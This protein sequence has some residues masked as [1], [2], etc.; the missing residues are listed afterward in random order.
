[1]KFA[2]IGAGVAGS[3]LGHM[4]NKQNHDVQ[5]FE[6]S[7]QENHWPVCA[8]GTSLKGI[9]IFA[10]KTGFDFNKYI[11]HRGKTAKV[12]NIDGKSEEVNVSGL[13]TYDKYKWESDLLNGLNVNYGVRCNKLNF[14]FHDYDY[15]IDCT[16]MN[17]EFLP[18][19]PF[20]FIIPSYEYLVENVENIDD[21][22]IINYRD[23]K[24]YF[25]YFPLGNKCGFVG[26]GDL[27]RNFHGISEFFKQNPNV[28]IIKKI[29]RP[30]RLTPPAL[31]QPFSS[32]NVIGAGEA[33]GCVFPFTG[34]GIVPS[35]ISCDILI[36][37][38]NNNFFDPMAY[39]EMILKTFSHFFDAYR[40]INLIANNRVPFIRENMNGL[41][42]IIINNPVEGHKI[43]RIAN[44]I[45]FLYQINYSSN[46]LDYPINNY[47]KL[48]QSIRNSLIHLSYNLDNTI[49]SIPIA[50]FPLFDSDD[51]LQ[52]SIKIFQDIC[53]N[54]IA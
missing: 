31:M 7:K 52:K 37:C 6:L 27:D 21:F 2:I 32:R 39:R 25:W 33:I 45:E 44:L 1:M 22:I 9:S 34:E 49:K 16:G 20:D 4:L 38:I 17:R 18:K 11:L 43:N 51:V 30:I 47:E 42:R 12:L 29:G 35:L 36:N 40:I 5:I 41:Q 54:K 24:G 53:N 50:Y 23:A 10:H 15:V 13:I 26:A 46:L 8:W 19:T 3:Y 48:K 28:K 14:P